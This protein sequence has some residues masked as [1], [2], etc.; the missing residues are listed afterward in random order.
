MQPT[1][2]TERLTLRP[3]SIE[4]APTV[5]SLV[6]NELIAEMTSNIPY[7]YT[8][9]DAVTWIS[10]HSDSFNQR[11]AV[12]YAVTLTDTGELIGAVSLPKLCDGLGVL[13]YWLGVD[14]WGNGF[15]TEATRAL[16]IYCKQHL[17]LKRLQVMHY[18]EN[19]R[20]KSVIKKLGIQYIEN[21]VSRIKDR[22]RDLCVYESEV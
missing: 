12:V 18:A 9:Q 16:I 7:P 14:Y 15:A 6:G 3:F 20:S 19:D 13:G 10:T 21:R 8:E 17:G 11:K 2:E 5:V 22:D 1:I 4:D